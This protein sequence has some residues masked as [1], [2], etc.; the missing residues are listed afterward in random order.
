MQ[1]LGEA[2]MF[3]GLR[4]ERDKKSGI[5]KLSQQSYVEA[6]LKR[7]GMVLYK[8]TS[9]PMEAGLQLQKGSDDNRLDKPHNELLGCLT[10]LMTTSRPD[11]SAAVSYLSQFQCKPTEAH[12]IHLK[13]ILRYL[14]GSSSRGLVYRRSKEADQQIVGFADANWATDENDRRSVSGYLFQIY[15]ATTSWTTK[16]QRTIVLSSTEAECSALEDCI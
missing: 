4:I 1:D 12:W 3:L 14:N 15:N 13:R 9:T 2:E 5:M 8:P 10:Y 11:L 6:V 16:K 7:F